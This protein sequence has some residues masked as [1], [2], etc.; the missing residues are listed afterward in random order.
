MNRIR[1]GFATQSGM[2]YDE[3]F[4]KADAFGFDFV[5]LLMDGVHERTRLADGVESIRTEATKHDLALM[6]HLPF[7][8]DI[9][10]PFEHVRNGAIRELRAAVETAAA[11]EAE[12][13]VVHATSYAWKPGWEK[14]EIQ[15]LLFESIRELDAHAEDHDIELCVENLNGGFVPLSDFPRLLERTDASLTI[16]TGHARVDGHDEEAIAEFIATHAERISHIHLN[17]TRRTDDDEHLP[18]GSGLLDFDRILEPIRSGWTG[19]LSLEVFTRSY[20]Y[21][22][23][24]KRHLDD[25]L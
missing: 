20:E 16:D 9:G 10:S 6:V 22:R 5:E 25:L 24:S 3:A 23:V 13:G 4:R 14:S 1:T 7:R 19:T 17:D 11:I 12:K 2:T 15:S 18:F 21:I 8:L